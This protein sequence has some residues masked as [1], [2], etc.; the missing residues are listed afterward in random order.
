MSVKTG[1][2]CCNCRHY[3]KSNDEKY[4]RIVYRCDKYDRCLSYVDVMTGWCRRWAEEK[5]GK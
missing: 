4:N 2:V 5:E 1:K 3:V